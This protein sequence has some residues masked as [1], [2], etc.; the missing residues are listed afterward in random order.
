LLHPSEV[1]RRRLQKINDDAFA[2]ANFGRVFVDRRS[3]RDKQKDEM[4]A[5]IARGCRNRD[6][7]AS[8]NKPDSRK[9]DESDDDADL[10]AMGFGS[11]ALIDRGTYE[12]G[13]ASASRLLGRSP[14]TLAPRPAN[15]PYAH[16]RPAP[17]I[18]A[19]LPSSDASY[20]AGAESAKRL[21]GTGAIKAEIDSDLR[22]KFAEQQAQRAS[23]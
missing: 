14:P 18:P 23:N 6:D 3:D 13:A 2:E 19:A 1:N 9:S 10:K 20:A 11:P 21:L 4:F 22:A 16:G 8:P 15:S 7:T 17:A 5:D 12:A